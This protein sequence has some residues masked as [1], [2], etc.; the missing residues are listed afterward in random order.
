MS[1]EGIVSGGSNPSYKG[2]AYQK[3]VTVWVALKL[4][5]GPA[6]LAD[7]IVVEPASHD[8]VA[9]K[10]HVPEE[11]ANGELKISAEG[12]LHVQI[13]FRGA[14]HWSAR[15]FADIVNDRARA[16]TRGPA[17]RAR[18]KSLLLKDARRRYVFITNR[19]VD[20]S[21][22]KGSVATPADRPD[23][24]FLPTHLGLDASAAASVK[25]RFAMIE[26]M[27]PTETRRQIDEI[28]TGAPLNVPLQNL[29][30]CVE[31][32]ER[33]V[34]D[35]FLEVPDPLR[36]SDIERVVERS[37]GRPHLDPRLAHYVAPSNRADIDR[38]LAEKHA[39][40]LIGPSGYGKSLTAESLADAMRRAE[41]P[42][43]VMRECDGIGDLESAFRSP[44]RVLFH[45]DDPWGQSGLDRGEAA[46]WSNLLGLWLRDASSEKVFVVTSRSE[47]Y[48]EALGERPAP[49][50][51]DRVAIV[52]DSSYSPDARRAILYGVLG[53][54]PSW[55]ADFA[56]QYES[57]VLHD[58]RSPFEI[59]GF[60]RALRAVPRP[61]DADVSSLID[62][63]QTDGR[64]HVAME[65]VKGFGDAGVRGAAVL[66]A[67]LRLSREVQD[68]RLRTLRRE[69]ES[70]AH[71]EIAL[72]DL[73]AHL[74]QTQLQTDA[75]GAYVAHSKVAEALEELARTWPR[76]A[77]T[78]L[79][80]AARAAL[81]L[82]AADASW[83]DELQR[84]FDA[85]RQLE[86]NGVL[87]SDD[88]VDAF[89]SLLMENLAGAVDDPRKFRS[90]WLAAARRLSVRTPVGKLVDWLARGAPR[91]KGGLGG[92]SWVAPE[93]EASDRSAA[94][95]A[96]PQLSI[97]K[98]FVAHVLPLAGED[99][100]AHEFLP[101]L[102][103]FDV[104]FTD[105][106]LAAG[107]I[108]SDA[109]RYVM[110]A[111]AISEGALLGA[112][113]PYNEVWTQIVR[114]DDAVDAALA[115]SAEERRKAWQGELDFVH[116][117]AIS[118][119]ADE[120][121]P[122]S[123]HYA[124]GYVRARRRAQGFS[125]IAQHPRPQ[126]I[127]PIW[128]EVMRYDKP[129]ATA[130]ELDAFFAA[131][132]AD[133]RLQ[134]DGLRVIGERRLA[135]GRD[136]VLAALQTGGPQALSAAVGALGWLESDDPGRSDKESAEAI[137][138]RTIG[139]LAPAQA[140][141]L[142][143]AIVDREIGAKKQQA[144]AER[145]VAAAGAS[146]A[147]VQLALARTL[148]L[149]DERLLD[150]FRRL[151]PSQVQATISG[152]PKPLARLLL[153][154][155]AAEG[156]DVIAIA[157]AWASSDDRDDAQAA[158]GALGFV[159]TDRATAAIE[160][161][162]THEDFEVRR[163]AIRIYA[164]R[165]DA[166][167]RRRLFAMVN[168]ESAPVRATLAKVIGEFG[169]S[170]GVP[171]LL[172][173][174]GDTRD[175][176]RHPERQAR[177]EPEYKVARTAAEVLQALAP[178]SA[179]TLASVVE[180]LN[181]AADAPVDYELQ[182]RLLRLL[183]E[184]EDP[185]HWG[186]L[187]R[188]LRDAHV[189]GSRTENLYPVRY[190][191][192]WSIVDRLGLHP[193]QLELAPWPALVKAAEHADPQL[194]APALM[195]LG[196]KLDA[197][198]DGAVLDALRSLASTPARTALALAM[199]DS[200]SKA[201]VLADKHDLLPADHPLLDATDEAAT[202]GGVHDSWPIS[203]KAQAWLNGLS[204]RDDVEKVLLWLM[205]KR[206]GR[207]FGESDFDPRALRREEQIPMLTIAD[208]AGMQ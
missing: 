36:K 20:A 12:E 46:R 89:D 80:A 135:F 116:Q 109:T 43:V 39:V 159:E 53:D 133:D 24:D 147:L 85:A 187:E 207:A 25:G 32:I 105:A 125:W 98:A 83:I 87:L 152:G 118:E 204:G 113:P 132:D 42:F 82:I 175:Y 176:V 60:A 106:F 170:D 114:M 119:Q 23:P 54:T 141:T 30:A 199:L 124:K 140:A 86:D 10:L 158:V 68:H 4:M 19:S 101:W 103:A 201:R 84:I 185:G 131:A 192:A 5:F 17:P 112:N 90:V 38:T 117:R 6:A 44:G 193:D 8:D 59:D 40:F 1:A 97:A 93:I 142:A 100:D 14:G 200:P 144:L 208:L 182:T 22:A 189:V 178:L 45:L 151:D 115:K 163:S 137:L 75:Q 92:F 136:R 49:I 64:R 195:A 35:R 27:T 205:S 179:K 78:A 37:G 65:H 168:D 128:A 2:Y 57:R 121:G 177:H 139:T 74:A 63:A 81:K 62:R 58:L 88:V 206:T 127:L 184:P 7:E 134:S 104:D 29:D 96:D 202:P 69:I 73:A 91:E 41:P 197:N 166:A 34:E 196:V 52:D 61:A 148:G 191:A 153:A 157:E 108:V 155:A 3:L 156:A 77:E 183:A 162:L 66:W 94:L 126:L 123:A 71:V 28:L 16:A 67:L 15:D 149:D 165:A 31:G 48:R 33:L 18:A 203:E 50:W 160:E 154:I 110:S 11:N 167:G 164:H 188:S 26:H 56:R 13:K 150:L 130:P 181:V 169:W 194:A 95:A 146:G 72:D 138:L 174:L 143:P 120:E 55:R 79:N 70:F 172:T 145:V 99:Y 9:A 76:P 21:L 111:D 171:T 107:S 129:E 180:A 198:P 161:A 47:I 102:A 51:A 190:A 173:L 186:A 122:S